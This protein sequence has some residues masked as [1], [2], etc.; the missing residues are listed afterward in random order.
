[1]V[2]SSPSM[3]AVMPNTGVAPA[4]NSPKALQVAKVPPVI[5]AVANAS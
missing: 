3:S 5:V 1:M 2:S 4:L